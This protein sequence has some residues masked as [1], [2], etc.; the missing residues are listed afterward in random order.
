MIDLATKYGRYGHRRITAL[1]Q[2]EG[3]NV[4]HKRVERP[5]RREGLKIFYKNNLKGSD[6]GLT[7]AHVFDY[8][9]SSRIIYGVMTLCYTDG[10]RA[11][12]FT[13]INAD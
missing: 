1:L 13:D 9:L 10:G 6:Y 4:N 11:S 8:G 7:M 5:W 12:F 3:W 2:R